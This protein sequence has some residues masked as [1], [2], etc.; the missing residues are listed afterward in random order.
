MDYSIVVPRERPPALR[1]LQLP[2]AKFL[3]HAFAQNIGIALAS[4]G[5][6]DDA[7]GNEFVGDDGRSARPSAMRAISNATPTT[8]LTS[9]SVPASSRKGVL[10]I[11][12][13][14]RVQAGARPVSQPPAYRSC[15]QRCSNLRR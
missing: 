2:L 15:R 7:L 10:G 5:K 8:R 12:Y 14:S 4:L 13:Y 6:F 3:E 1:V 9:G 11:R